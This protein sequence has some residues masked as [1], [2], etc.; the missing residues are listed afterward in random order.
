M[1]FGAEWWSF[2][3]K[4]VKKIKFWRR[5]GGISRQKRQNNQVLAQNGGLRCAFGGCIMVRLIDGGGNV[6]FAEGAFV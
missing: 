6:N 3:A 1:I 5:M 2:R 4:S